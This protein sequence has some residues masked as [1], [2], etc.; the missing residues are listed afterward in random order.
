MMQTGNDAI[1]NNQIEKDP[2]GFDH[3][4]FLKTV[5]NLPGVYR[6]IDKQRQV[7]YVG[8]AKDLKKR[9][10]SYFRSSGLSPKTLSLVGHI[11]SIEVINTRTES[12]ALILEN[13][14]IKNLNPRYNILFRDDKS[15]PYIQLTR[16]D[17]PRLKIY[18][19]VTNSSKGQFFGPFP[20]VGAIRYSLQHLQR[21]FKLRNC[22][23]AMFK[24]RSRPCLQYQIKRC[25]GPCVELVSKEEY[26]LQISQAELFLK[27]QNEKLISDHVLMMEQAS[28]SLNFEKAAEYR[29]NIEQLR[30]VNEKQFVTGFNSNIDIIACA[31]KQ[32]ISCIQVFMIRNGTSLGNK[33]FFIRI[34]LDSSPADIIETFLMQHYSRHPIPA[35][36]IVNQVLENEALLEQALSEIALSKISIKSTVRGK[37]KRCAGN[38]V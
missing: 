24:N 19:G 29:D 20:S 15:Y 12:E 23:D 5:N 10:S 9:L 22:E 21:I 2:G 28:A 37:R 31:L 6:M 11:R 8:K 18:R 25:S 34:K 38:G 17:F 35:E 27:G 14:L 16:H 13:D 33:P 26:R 1:E 32:E 7:I 36:I 30:T 3:Q 4:A